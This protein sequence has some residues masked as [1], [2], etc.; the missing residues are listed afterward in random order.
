MV[1][2]PSKKRVHNFLGKI[3]AV[4]CTQTIPD[5]ASHPNFPH[6]YS[7]HRICR[8]SG[9]TPRMLQTHEKTAKCSRKN[10]KCGTGG[11]S[12]RDGR[13]WGKKR[14]IGGVQNRF[15]GGL[16]GMFSP[17]LSLS[18]PFA[19]LCILWYRKSIFQGNFTQQMC[20]CNIYDQDM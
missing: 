5:K 9:S 13:A 4:V 6:S 16:Y 7:I 18:P 3:G 10:E 8:A 17:S 1:Y 19:A 12:A 2:T 14:I 11:R 20:S 15:C